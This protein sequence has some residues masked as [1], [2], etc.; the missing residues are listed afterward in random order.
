MPIRLE[1][2]LENRV[3][4]EASDKGW[5][6]LKVQVLGHRGFPDRWFVRRAQGG[7]YPEIIMIEFKA[8]GKKPRKLQVYVCAKLRS[9]GFEVHECVDNYEDAKRI[10]R[11]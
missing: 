3:C 9:V 7:H 2:D 11:L 1:S 10:L 8:P 4:H 6:A 5:W